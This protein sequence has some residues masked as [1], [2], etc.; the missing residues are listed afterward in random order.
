MNRNIYQRDGHT[1]IKVGSVRSL[2]SWTRQWE[3]HTLLINASN[4][5]FQSIPEKDFEVNFSK[6]CP[7]V[8]LGKDN[9]TRTCFEGN[10]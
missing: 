8:A 5:Q 7:A 9:V 10:S 2:N 6:L 3:R 4:N 1:Y